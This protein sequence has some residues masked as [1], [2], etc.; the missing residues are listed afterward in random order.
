MPISLNMS[1][2]QRTIDD[3]PLVVVRFSATWCNP[4]KMFA[5]IFDRVAAR[6]SSVVFGIVDID[7][8]KALAKYFD[9]KAVPTTVFIRN[10]EVIEKVSAVLTDKELDAH[11]RALAVT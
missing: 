11:V 10:A 5:P 2:F 8:E 9:V 7:K 1:N 3:N 4:C 6:S